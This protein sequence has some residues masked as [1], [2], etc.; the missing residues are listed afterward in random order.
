MDVLKIFHREKNKKKIVFYFKH[1]PSET[2]PCQ[3]MDDNC[4]FSTNLSQQ[5]GSMKCNR[6]RYFEVVM[7][8]IYYKIRNKEV[9]HFILILN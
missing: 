8:K 3:M 6:T 9:Q 5:N 1:E 2:A 7:K 4:P